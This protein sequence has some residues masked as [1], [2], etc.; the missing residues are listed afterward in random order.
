MASAINDKGKEPWED[1]LQDSKL[2][3][4]VDSEAEG[5]VEEDTRA[6]P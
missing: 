6:Y 2:E 1:D 4:E 5:G 3:E